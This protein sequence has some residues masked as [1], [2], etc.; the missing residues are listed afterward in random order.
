M[1]DFLMFIPTVL[2]LMFKDIF[3]SISWKVYDRRLWKGTRYQGMMFTRES[4][5]A[6]YDK[7][8]ASPVFSFENG[9]RVVIDRQ[10]NIEKV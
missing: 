8:Y 3:K 4:T 2:Y 9:D 6:N 1:K 10:G 7:T 5:W